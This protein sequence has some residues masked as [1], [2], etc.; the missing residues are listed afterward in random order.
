MRGIMFALLGEVEDSGVSAPESPNFI[1]VINI[2]YNSVDYAYLSEYA[3]LNVISLTTVT[4]DEEPVGTM[5]ANT[6]LSYDASLNHLIVAQTPNL[7][8][9]RLDRNVNLVEEIGVI[10]TQGLTYS[11]EKDTYFQLTT[12]GIVAKDA[13]AN[14]LYTLLFPATQNNP[15]SLH[16][17]YSLDVF[18]VSYDGIDYIYVWKPDFIGLTLAIEKELNIVGMQEGVC[19][20][21]RTGEIWTNRIDEKRKIDYDGNDLFS[22]PFTASSGSVNEGLVIDP[23]DNTLWFNSDEYFHGGITD[24]NRLWHI[25]PE[26]KYD[27]TISV[28]DQIKYEW[29]A[30]D[31]CEIIDNKLVKINETQEATWTSPIFDMENREDLKTLSNYSI[32]PNMIK[33]SSSEP[34]GVKYDIFP[35]DYFDEWGLITPIEV[36]YAGIL[37]YVQ[38]EFSF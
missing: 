19:Y 23:T 3:G 12:T 22:F 8:T 33:T 37:R 20:S 16:Y 34:T 35:F 24:G 29:G 26:K 28:P 6:G 36:S 4:P 10:A 11:V 30:L 32:E 13:D 25:D 7:P 18:F 15:G 27:K 17:S 14:V 5:A 21:E 38:F 9:L 1:D 2:N 31:N